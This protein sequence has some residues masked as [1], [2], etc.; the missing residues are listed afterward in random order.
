MSEIVFHFRFSIHEI[1]LRR[2]L[3]FFLVFQLFIF[4]N[5]STQPNGRPDQPYDEVGIELYHRAIGTVPIVAI[6]KGTTVFVQPMDI[7]SFIKVRADISDDNSI[8]GYYIDESRRYEI[9]IQKRM[10]T[11]QDQIFTLKEEDFIRTAMGTYM[12]ISI[13]ETVFNL[14]ADFTFSGLSVELHSGEPLPAESEVKYAKQRQHMFGQQEDFIPDKRFGFHRTIFSLGTL[15]YQAG[16]NF[17]DIG[18][19]TTY[20]LIAG[21]QLLGGD[22]DA[23]ISGSKGQSIEWKNIPW[24]WRTNIQNTALLTQ[25]I[26]GRR[27]SFSNLHLPDSMVGIQIT[28]AYTGYRSSYSNYTISDRTDPNWIVELY[29]NEALVNYTKADQ[30]GYY[31][32]VIPLSY[33]S[34]H[35]QLKFRGPYGEVRT[36]IIDLQIPFTFLPPGNVEYTVTGGTSIDHPSLSSMTGKF[37]TKIG[38]STAMTIGGGLRYLRDEFG[39]Q[40]YLPYGTSS[41]RLTSGILVAGEYYHGSGY[42]STLSITGPAGIS[43]EGS[44]EHPFGQT[45]GVV[46][47]MNIQDRRKIQ[48]LTPLPW[49]IGTLHASA[50]DLPINRDSGNFF[51]TAQA[52]FRVVNTSIDLSFSGNYLRNKFRFRSNGSIALGTVGISLSL[53][54]A[55]FFHPMAN[56]DY[57]NRKVLSIEATLTKMFNGFAAVNISGG[58]SFIPNEY[59][60][61]IDLRM[62]LDFA[63]VGLSCGGGTSQPLQ[64]AATIQG[65][66]AYDPP[67]ME[68][69]A[70]NLPQVRRGGLEVLPFLDINNNGKRDKS[71]PI[72]KHFGFEQSPGKITEDSDGLI[73]IQN[74]EPYRKYILKT[75][76][77]NVENISW[78][79]KFTSFE[80]IP[81]ANGFARMEIPLTIAGQ[82]EGYIYRNTSHGDEP[83]GGVRVIIRH[84][85]VDDTSQ[86]KLTEDLLSYS[87][88]EFYYLGLPPGKYRASIDP[89]QLI[90]LHST[91]IPPFIDFEMRFKDEG[92]VVEGLNFIVQGGSAPLTP[93]SNDASKAL[94]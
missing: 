51:L 64:A 9:D 18:Q 78:I 3:Y 7:F 65:S 84:N 20:S 4:R 50:M 76:T 34:T 22:F 83:L 61:Q 13:F 23:S 24:Q 15:D 48:I 36:K 45:A 33:G 2:S 43:I 59:H 11:Y 42:S 73:R 87:T 94:K 14:R 80:F 86:V 75:S 93:R 82:V 46:D 44:Y 89:K 62:N 56:L 66:L 58:H 90:P 39:K 28:N 79:P 31:K 27:A 37:D 67:A 1:K 88:G 53:P 68:F 63:Q 6:L 38:I 72:V 19:M 57:T 40:H 10:V 41:L 12:K 70:N 21:G 74:M 71:E 81:P 35:V 8:R 17:S 77:T 30:T 52:L 5:G 69:I 92:D 16:G 25:I 85:E 26:V 55:I 91:S 60:G 49:D 29:I 32:F 54:E 47:E